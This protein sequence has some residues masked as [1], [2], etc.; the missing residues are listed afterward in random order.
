MAGDTSATGTLKVHQYFWRLM[1]FRPRFYVT[2]LTW[3]TVHFALGTVQG[4][5]LKAYFDGLTGDAARALDLWQVVGLQV[6]WLALSLISFYLAVIAFVNFTFHGRAL[7]IRNMLARVLDMPGAKPLPPDDDGTPMS[8]GKVISTMRDDADQMLES[9]I[10]IDDVVALSVTAALSFAIMFRISPVVT[11]CTFIPLAVV[12]AIAQRLGRR[13]RDY[14]R[15]SRAATAE[16]TGMIADMFSSTLAIK[17]ADAEDRVVERFRLVNA[18]RRQAMVRDRL[19]TQVVEALSSGTVDV[20]VGLILLAAARGMHAGAFTVGD[21]A[22]FASYIWPSTHLMRMTGL[23][24]TRYRQVGVSAQR[25]EALMQGAPVGAVVEH[26]QIFMEGDIPPASQTSKSEGD[27]LDRL[28]VEGLSYTH[29]DGTPALRDVDLALP[30]GSLTV[31]TG[32]IGSGKSTLLKVLLGLLPADAGDVRWNGEVV[33]DPRTFLVPPRAAYTGQVPRLFSASLRDNIL[34]GAPAGHTDVDGAVR[35]AVLERDVAEMDDGL[36]TLVGPRGVRLSG[37]QLQRAAAARMFARDADLLVFDDLSSALDVE[38]E[39]TMWERLFDGASD[40]LA[41]AGA[42]RRPT[43]LVVSHRPSVLRRAD[44]IVVMVDGRVA[45]QG[46]LEELLE[47]SSE[48]R[49]L[50]S[51]EAEGD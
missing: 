22:L 48:M 10:V 23:L 30:R 46:T 8:T 26:N 51:E 50:W 33:D 18:R 43:C 28:T 35:A 34:L 2:D 40:E 42:E 17:V 12:I 24:L 11:L 37:G 1:R 36:D 49:R 29:E 27:R 5:I 20:G 14:R 32:R 41:P 19:L 47:S 44:N 39:R 3:A 13:A 16:V 15:A 45:A 31:V 9:I 7:L 38:T 21:F 6:G 4:L 25:M